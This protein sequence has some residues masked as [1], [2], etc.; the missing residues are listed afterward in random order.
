MEAAFA[1]REKSPPTV[2][3]TAQ[4][5]V[6]FEVTQVQPPQTPTFQQIK[7]QVTQQFRQERV[8]MLLTTKTRELSDRA[9]AEHDLKRA[10]K[11]LGATVK[12]SELVGV[13]SQVPDLG[14]M[15]GAAGQAFE[16]KVG[17]ISGPIDSGRSGAVLMLTERKEPSAAELQQSAE[18]IREE[19]LLRKRNETLAVYFGGLRQQL[20]REG[21]IKINEDELKTLTR[22][23]FAGS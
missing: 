16:L 11:E 7:Q 21:K 2:T 4:A 6:I 23:T 17:E 22:N 13:N 19:L 9:R 12:T 5:I 18:R 8:R 3:R 10:A 20:Q 15:S 14:S 1:A